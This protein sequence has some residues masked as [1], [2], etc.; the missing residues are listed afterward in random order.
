MGMTKIAENRLKSRGPSPPQIPL[1]YRGPTSK[2]PTSKGRGGDGR[3]GEGRGGAAYNESAQGCQDANA[4]PVYVRI[5]N[6][7]TIL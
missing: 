4:G 3:G 1:N 5:I 7:V 6:N 2:A